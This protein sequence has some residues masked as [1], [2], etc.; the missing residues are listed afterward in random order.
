[1]AWLMVAALG[2][3][4]GLNPAMG[5]LFAVAMGQ[6]E[7]RSAAVLLAL[8]PIAMGH[9]IS[10]ACVVSVATVAGTV[11]PPD[12]TRRLG[13]VGV[14]GFALW[15]L[16]R[17]G[18]HPRWV[19]MRLRFGALVL[20][21][22]LMSTAHGAGL[23]LLPALLPAVPASSLHMHVVSAPLPP[24]LLLVVHTTAMFGGM[25][26]A[27]LLVHHLVGLDFLRRGWINLE[28]VWIGALLLAAA[29]MAFP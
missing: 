25:A 27:A 2:A 17:R 5:W 9:L 21:S 4:H 6:Q 7:R 10:V 28:I 1:M 18:K 26:A 8:P 12:E 16:A 3:Y 23:M 29:S 13:A 22:L 20:W 11:L 15:L 14:A 24:L 19:G